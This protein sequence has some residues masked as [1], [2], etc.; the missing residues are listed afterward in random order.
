MTPIDKFILAAI[1]L[2]FISVSFYIGYNFGFGDVTWDLLVKYCD[3]NAGKYNCDG[4]C[5]EKARTIIPD[6]NFQINTFGN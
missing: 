3:T 6:R 5:T 2:L 1:I 4:F